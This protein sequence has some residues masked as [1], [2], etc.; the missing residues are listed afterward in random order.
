V[1][2]NNVPKYD[3]YKQERCLDLCHIK[4]DKLGNIQGHSHHYQEQGLLPEPPHSHPV[5][6]RKVNPGFYL[7]LARGRRLDE[8]SIN[9]NI[10]W[11]IPNTI[12]SNNAPHYSPSSSREVSI[13]K[14]S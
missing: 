1:S 4:W 8:F 7:Y 3:R 9:L 5:L 14:Y 12:M 13:G 10:F 2:N 11:S 6:S